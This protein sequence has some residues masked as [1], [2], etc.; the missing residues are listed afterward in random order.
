MTSQTVHGAAVALAQELVRCPS[1]TPETSAAFD[2]LEAR[3]KTSGFRCWRLPF[4]SDSDAPSDNLYAR[5]GKAEPNLCFAGHLDVVPI[6]DNAAWS[7]PPFAGEI[8]DGHL[9]GRGSSDMK[10]AIAA[11]VVAAEEFLTT[12]DGVPNGSLSL[13]ITGDEEGPAKNGTIRVLDWLGERGEPIDGCIVG[14]PTNPDHL[15]QAIKIGRRGSLN[16]RLR[17]TGQQGH[18]AYPHRADNPVPKL[19]KLLAALPLGTIDQG[20][21]YFEPSNLEITSLE[22]DASAFNVIP[23][24]AEAMLSL[25]FNTLHTGQEV[26]ARLELACKET[27]LDHELEFDLKGE[28][29]LTAP[30]R[31]SEAL[32][33][34]IHDEIGCEPELAT[35]GGTSDARFIKDYCPVVEFGLISKTIHA[36]DEYALTDDID[37][38]QRIYGRVIALLLN[39]SAA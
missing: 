12:T 36:V 26:K 28:P 31:L 14:E 39:G 27:G 33:T 6:G 22:T 29:F 37:V 19:L 25:R 1:V 5:I 32:Q 35:G 34:A 15:G 9:W 11:F 18:V 8:A 24:R 3:L 10:G 38:L 17:V 7:R 4:G 16:L 13:L 20:N 21:E 23:G 30:G 2:L